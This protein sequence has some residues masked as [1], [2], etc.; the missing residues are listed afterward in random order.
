[1]RIV[2]WAAV[3]LL[4]AL[5]L[6][7]QPVYGIDRDN[8]ADPGQ[9]SFL[10]PILKDVEVI[11]LAESIHMTH[12]FPP[13][14]LGIVRYLNETLGIHVLVMEGSAPD[15]WIAQD[16]LLNSAHSAQDAQEA[17]GGYFGLW[18]TIEMRKLIEYEAGS[19]QS[20]R[21]LYIAGYD[22]QPGN[23]RS[24][25]GIDAFRQL[26][27][28][29]SIYSAP[30]A[31]LDPAQWIDRIKPLVSSD[32][33]PEQH[34][35]V[36]TALRDLEQWIAR[37]A[38]EVEKRFPKVPHASALRLIPANLRAALQF[39]DDL[40]KPNPQ[41][42]QGLRDIHAGDYVLQL[43][44]ALPSG[45][46]MLW[47]HLSHLHN[48]NEQGRASVGGVLHRSLGPRLYT[49][50]P[51]AESGGAILLFPA[52]D[53]EDLGYGRVHGAR[54]SLGQ[55]LSGLSKSDYFLDLRS[56]PTGP[57]A[58]P[59][60][61]TRQ[62][63]QVEA[64]QQSWAIAREFDGIVWIKTVHAPDLT[65]FVMTASMIHYRTALT[66][67][68]IALVAMMGVLLIYLAVRWSRASSARS[69]RSR[70]PAAHSPSRR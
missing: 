23:G 67:I 38:P 64:A 70:A 16:R 10:G 50:A 53:N 14:R 24:S 51:F 8:Y 48:N 3:V 62:P 52:N 32:Y 34:T 37:A 47:A 22:V 55:R 7:A 68:G 11:S 29:L 66:V 41:G 4:G 39:R 60:F 45:K 21:P 49:I 13:V 2:A 56:L 61:W 63:L 65:G 31:G 9:F 25:Q 12:E 42:Y 46:F 33:N 54:G 15:V 17:L 20:S 6:R 57:A 69:S 18:N 36:E 28:R 35:S 44:R 40:I 26:A 19:W 59:V 58:D 27:E 1:M 43:K 5:G 30:P